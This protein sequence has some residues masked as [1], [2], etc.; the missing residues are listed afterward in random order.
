LSPVTRTGGPPSNDTVQ[1]ALGAVL[2]MMFTYWLLPAT[3]AS[4]RP[5]GDQAGECS[6]LP[7]TS[8]RGGP[9]PI[10]RSSMPNV[11]P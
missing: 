4:R 9:P 1:I 2:P 5:S 10:G 6:S 8:S 3:Y 7:G 11:S